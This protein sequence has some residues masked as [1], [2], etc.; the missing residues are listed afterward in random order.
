MR[1]ALVGRRGLPRPAAGAGTLRA[2]TWLAVITAAIVGV[3]IAD[4]TGQG[5]QIIG[6]V[7]RFLLFYSGVFALLA[8]TGAVV[9]GLADTDRLFL[10]PKRRIAGQALH[11]A[12][13]LG[14]LV[15]LAAHV[16]L[17][18]AAH[19]SHVVDA[20]VP[21]LARERTLYVGLGTI[22][23]DLLVL[24]IITSVARGRF[25]SSRPRAWRAIHATAYVAW[26]FAILHGLLAGRT[27]KPYVDWSYGVCVA[28][29][30]VALL[31]RFRTDKHRVGGRQIP[32][33]AQPPVGRPLAPR[34]LGR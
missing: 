33:P 6:S 12:L 13:A 7:Q 25:A 2:L 29:V 1:H 5:R 15:T 34:E 8:L 31:V 9:V 21:F 3:V 30:A 10:T 23:S 4:H 32:Q 14:A 26:V 28:L 27:A 17:E 24:I 11:R 18:I 20:V 22:A 19:R 16:V